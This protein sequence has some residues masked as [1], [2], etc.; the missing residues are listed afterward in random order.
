MKHLKH[1]ILATPIV[2][3]TACGTAQPAATSDPSPPPTEVE[4]SAS[5]PR[6]VIAHDGGLSTLDLGTGKVVASDAAEGFLRLNG[7]GDGRHVLVSDTGG[8]RVYDAGIRAEAHGDHAHYYASAPGFTGITYPAEKPGHVVT[9]GDHVTLFGD[10]DG[11]IQTLP[12]GSIADESAKAQRSATSSPHHGVAL[13]LGDAT[14]LHTEGSTEHRETVRAVRE[15][16]T[17]AETN[18]CPDVHGEATAV[19]NGGG[20]VAVF[21]CTTGPVVYR[22]G[23]FTKVPI[24]GDYGRSGTLVGSVESAIVLADYA[25]AP[26]AKPGQ[27]TKVALIDASSDTLRTV[28]LGASYWFRSLARGPHDEALVLTTDGNLTVIDPAKGEVTSTVQVIGAWQENEDWQAP[29]PILKVAGER[30]YVTDAEARELVVIDLHTLKVVK[31]HALDVAPTELVLATGQ[32][33]GA[34]RH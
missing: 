10:G 3:L 18:A 15:G 9:H 11:S 14:L 26:D 34:G 30:A 27:R 23:A 20:E 8:F 28:E 22:D 19:T 12:I 7:A 1:L 16:L 33:E 24:V 5:H 2:L 29:G 21:G 31:R 4:I 25:D 17:V 13:Q 6:A 32:P